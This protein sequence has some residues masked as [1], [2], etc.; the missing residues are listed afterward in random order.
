LDE[1]MRGIDYLVLVVNAE[2]LDQRGDFISKVDRALKVAPE[3]GI[4]LIFLIVGET[5]RPNF[6]SKNINTPTFYV[7][8]GFSEKDLV[9]MRSY[10]AQDMRMGHRQP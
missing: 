4:Q 6:L 5:K 3:A 8:N 9:L 7:N 10:I 2:S 1:G